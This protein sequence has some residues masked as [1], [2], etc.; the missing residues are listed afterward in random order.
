MITCQLLVPLKIHEKVFTEDKFSII[1]E[2][3]CKILKKHCSGYRFQD[4]KG[5]L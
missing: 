2:K 4:K 1:D 3:P 5:H